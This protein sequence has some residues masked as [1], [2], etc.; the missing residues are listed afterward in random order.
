VRSLLV[1]AALLLSSALVLADDHSVIF[2]EDVDFSTFKTFTMRDATIASARPEL[3]FP[4]VAESL[5]VSVRAALVASGL[6]DLPDRGDL[7]AESSVKGVD[8]EIGPLGRANVVRPPRASGAG[9]AGSTVDFTEVTLV[10]DL[11][12]A[13]SEVLIWRGV[14]HDTEKDAGKL[15]DALPK[16]AA[17][18][19]SEFPPRKKK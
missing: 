12:R 7:V 2:D 5:G 8:Y 6:K 19:L 16:D 3:Q 11:K 1:C 15:A 17:K 9:P 18:L 4:A 13:G 14:Y 10:V